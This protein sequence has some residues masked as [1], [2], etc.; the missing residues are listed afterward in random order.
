M[1]ALVGAVVFLVAA[2]LHWAE[3]NPGK[4]FDLWSLVLVGL[5]L[6]ALHLAYPLVAAYRSRTRPNP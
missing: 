5:F 4:P 6:V 1:L 2:V 3:A